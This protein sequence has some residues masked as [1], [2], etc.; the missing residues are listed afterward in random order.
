MKSRETIDPL[1]KSIELHQ[2]MPIVE[3]GPFVPEIA[4]EMFAASFAAADSGFGVLPVVIDSDGGDVYALMS[5]LDIWDSNDFKV[6][7]FAR[8]KAFS[9]GAIALAFGTPGLR[10]IAPRCSYMLHNLSAMFGEG[11]PHELAGG[12]KHVQQMEDQVFT[13]MAK[14]CGQPDRF[15]FDLLTQ[16]RHGDVYLTPQEVLEYGIADHVGTPIISRK[17]HVDFEI[18]L[19]DGTP[20]HSRAIPCRGPSL[21]IQAVG[22]EGSGADFCKKSRLR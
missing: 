12:V 20:V 14:R 10:F 6:C 4:T 19:P 15:F 21:S 9:A 16:H 8:G 7:T 5:I 3:I 1:L 13:E 11:K 18:L 22:S 2:D 17:L